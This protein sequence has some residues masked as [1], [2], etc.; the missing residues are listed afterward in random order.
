M[1]FACINISSDILI[2]KTQE[3]NVPFIAKKLLDCGVSLSNIYITQN[4]PAEISS[5]LSHIDHDFVIIIGENN[6]V[7]NFNIKNTLANLWNEN[8]AKNDTCVAWVQNYFK[9][10]NL[11]P[12]ANCENEYFTINNSIPLHNA[13]SHLQGF[14]YVSNKT[15]YVFMPNDKDAIEFLFNNSL[16][17]IITKERRV[18]Y[19]TININTFGI[20]EKDIMSALSD[21]IDNNYNIAISTYAHDLDVTITVRY[22][23]LTPNEIV[24]VFISKIYEKLRK[25]I[26]SDGET[27]LY[28]MALDLI[29]VSNKTLAIAETITGGNICS[30]F[31][32]CNSPAKNLILEG[33][34]LNTQLGQNNLL[35]ISPAIVNKFGEVSVECA[36]E[37]A[38]SLLETSGADIVL[39]TCGDI[40]G[41][42][43]ICYIAVGDMDGI[44]VYKNTYSGN[45]NKVISTVSKC[46]AFYLIK[47]LKQNDLFF[48]TIKV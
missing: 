48:N 3:D 43:N 9:T 34:I 38:T 20:S 22:N 16:L 27:G 36:Y 31:N 5:I 39:V 40:D 19:D 41:E 35:N 29:T 1:K 26:Y 45:K 23:A 2:G 25:Y 4:L 7:K 46:G 6:S 21:L 44:H 11:L 24:S 15:S 8:I 37:M 33:R 30:E 14:M 18:A 42:S 28:Q 12:I 47:K 10:N 13:T 32:K 17:P